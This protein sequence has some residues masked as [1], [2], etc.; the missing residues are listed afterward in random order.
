MISILMPCYNAGNYLYRSIK[1]I[2]DSTVQDFEIVCMDDGSTD[3]TLDILHELQEKDERIRVFTREEKGYAVTMNELLTEAKGDYVLNVDPDDWIEPDMLEKMLEYMNDDVDFVKCGF[4]FELK[5]G[6]QKYQ[7]T[8]IPA[9]FCPR[10]L[11]LREKTFFFSSQVAIWTCLIRRSFIEKHKVRLNETPGAAYQDTAFVFM[12]NAL[13]E[14]VVTIPDILYHYNKTNENASTASTRYPFAPAVEY[15]RM[16]KW[17][18]DNPKYG[19]EVRE[20]LCASRFGSYL[21]NMSRIK[22]EDRLEFAKMVQED[23]QEDWKYV[24]IENFT[25][26]YYEAYLTAKNDPERFVK[27]FE[28]VGK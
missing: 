28:G 21:W 19:K 3:E 5:N 13:A 11:P 14:K 24:N 2:Q 7:Y 22:R 6:Q 9:E 25:P 8:T 18:A 26:Y 16:A 15:R 20:V 12:I 4:V 17:C 1:S 10:K 23:L 27:M